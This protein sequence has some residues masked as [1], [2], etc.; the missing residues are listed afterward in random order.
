MRKAIQTILAMMPRFGGWL[1]H[2]V[3]VV[4]VALVSTGAIYDLV[5]PADQ[6]R[7]IAACMVILYLVGVKMPTPSKESAA[8][9]AQK[10]E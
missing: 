9:Q 3:G 5:P 8:P 1:S 2:S 4:V 10:K 7:A 6:R